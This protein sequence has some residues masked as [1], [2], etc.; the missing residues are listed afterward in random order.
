[1]KLVFCARAPCPFSRATHARIHDLFLVSLITGGV[2]EVF[3]F[4]GLKVMILNTG[5]AANLV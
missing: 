2:S 1:M 5:F 4:L 3:L